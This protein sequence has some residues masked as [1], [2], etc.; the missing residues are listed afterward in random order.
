MDGDR[1]LR[2]EGVRLRPLVEEDIPLLGRWMFDPDV[3]HWLQLSEDPAELRTE[4]AVRER[5]ERMQADPFTE[6]W[7]IDT[8]EG[9]PVGQIEL[10]EIHPVQRR[11][12]M[13]LLVGEKDTWGRGY[14]ARAVR[15]LVGYAF[16][17]LG[18]RRVFAMADRDNVRV[19]RLFERCGFVREGLLR[20][21]RLRH[22]EPTDMVVMGVLDDDYRAT[23]YR[24]AG[25]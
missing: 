10:V 4:E 12:E 22:G 24:S 15:R 16:K 8:A 20:R 21:H 19:I 7:R 3:L 1:V 9:K 5:Y 23:N 6:T 13:H 2:G 25:E 11:A 18:L 17:D 14:G